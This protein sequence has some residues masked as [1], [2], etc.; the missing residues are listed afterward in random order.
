MKRSR[1]EAESSSQKKQ[2][3]GV[4]KVQD[5]LGY[6]EKVKNR[7]SGQPVIYNQFLDIMKE[8][9]CQAIDTD[10]VIQRVK[11]LFKGNKS[12]MLGFN[13]FL[14]PG[15]KI[16]IDNDGG[17]KT[18]PYQE[19]GKPTIEFNHAVQ[20]VA[21]IK[22][23]FK[24][25]PAIYA[26]FL[27]I[28]H[29]YQAK[30][31]IDEVY[32]R[33]QKLFGDQPDLLNEFKYFLPDQN[34]PQGSLLRPK[35]KDGKMAS[36]PTAN[37][38]REKERDRG[39][40]RLKIDRIDGKKGP[41]SAQGP[42][43]GGRTIT[44]PA[45]SEKDLALFEKIKQ[46]VTRQQWN[47]FMKTLAMYS[48][49]II[50]RTELVRMVDDVL[51]GSDFPEKFRAA[52]SFDEWEERQLAAHR[53]NY[54]AFVA[55]ADFSTCKEVTPSYRQLPSE[56]QSLSCSGRS[57]LSDQ[58]LN[59]RCISIPTGSE[60]FSFKST[61]KNIYEENL[62]K[63]EDERFEL[64]LI[65]ENNAAAIHVLEDIIEE[66]KALEDA[67]NPT[68]KFKLTSNLDI[69]HIRAI[70]RVYG[71]QGQGHGMVEL[72]RQT[73]AIAAPKIL[74]RLKQKEEE[75]KRVR[76]ELKPQWKKINEQNYQRSLDHR[77]FY[78]KQEDKN[79]RNKKAMLA[80][81]REL[82]AQIFG[83]GRQISD[84]EDSDAESDLMQRL[85]QHDPPLYTY[86]M[87]FPYGDSDVHDQIYEIMT[88][89]VA[90]VLSQEDQMKF[91]TF[92]LGFV[93]HFFGAKVTDVSKCMPETAG[94]SVE[95]EAAATEK[96]QLASTEAAATL[97]NFDLTQESETKGDSEGRA[98]R[99][100]LDQ[101]LLGAVRRIRVSSRKRKEA[102]MDYFEDDDDDDNE[103]E[104]DDGKHQDAASRNKRRRR[105]RR[106]RT[107]T[108]M[109][110]E[111]SDSDSDA[112]NGKC[113]GPPIKLRLQEATE[114]SGQVKPL[115]VMVE[116]WALEEK[117][118]PVRRHLRPSR[119]FICNNRYYVF[120]RLHQFLYDRLNTA[121][122]LSTKKHRRS[123]A[124]NKYLPMSS[125][126]RY[127]RFKEMLFQLLD[128]QME[129]NRFEDECRTLLGASSFALFTV[130]KLVSQLVKQT[131]SLLQNSLCMKLLALYQFEHLQYARTPQSLVRS[132][133]RVRVY[134]SRCAAL[135]GDSNLVQIEYFDDTHHLGIGLVEDGYGW[136]D[137]KT[138]PPIWETR[139][140]EILTPAPTKLEN[141]PFLVRNLKK[142]LAKA[143]PDTLQET[144]KK[145]PPAKKPKKGP[146][147]KSLEA[148]LLEVPVP[149][150]NP[151]QVLEDVASLNSLEAQ[152]CSTTFKYLWVP[153][154]EDRFIRY[155]T[156]AKVRKALHALRDPREDK[157]DP[158]T[159][160]PPSADFGFGG[161]TSSEVSSARA[162]VGKEGKLH[163]AARLRRYEQTAAQFKSGLAK[164][165]EELFPEMNLESALLALAS[166][167]K[168]P[169]PS[170]S[171]VG[172]S[173]SNS[174][175]SCSSSSSSSSS[176]SNSGMNNSSGGSCSSRGGSSHHDE[177]E[178]QEPDEE[179]EEPDDEEDDED[180]DA[181]EGARNALLGF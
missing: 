76:H 167:N 114:G 33:V 177:E 122:D 137:A 71:E 147:K 85:N 166:F 136:L 55:S 73:P 131:Q 118:N 116:T 53:F 117:L 103:E 145:K 111:S 153:E 158:I 172:I 6:L 84:S 112:E 68:D 106:Q 80:E 164:K 4:P 62:F 41:E 8:F 181:E 119:L 72:L 34:Q 90:R 37:K 151:L 169:E 30:R 148:G 15:F 40:S 175:S 146:S 102:K 115:R 140:S 58:V 107:T 152:I 143:S 144:P 63:C 10:G 43:P 45:G 48:N 32:S 139:V 154:T 89:V 132:A 87:R 142:Y 113:I 59:D 77:S 179:E 61:R 60:D 65:I 168:S 110:K 156:Q 101:S 19:P 21:K 92:W 39:P 28:L 18:P 70:A 150:A 95:E 98:T 157:K 104:E 11:T 100:S 127:K 109:K 31:T 67:P 79:R 141:P 129:G 74:A 171:S 29:D 17:K 14:P 51:A 123:M 2:T 97:L 56:V 7:F 88:H 36:S 134:Q 94:S 130:D 160:P 9:K 52:I 163:R 162:Q 66:C 170:N 16:E 64:D 42:V 24:D 124:K 126:A 108:A 125:E 161:Y 174:G 49:Q 22:N 26:E 54:Y 81:L 46:S 13:Q 47:Q 105:N 138:L 149:T 135:L 165:F 57:A 3:V 44:Y 155:R 38:R 173:S 78:F 23:R 120:F 128:G 93:H 178:E 75:W 5:A 69:L 133:E 12:L 20:Y 96:D 159:I 83:S 50:T 99:G 82:N 176:N 86:C 35:A 27:D 121:K 1:R 91:H 25:Q 180:E